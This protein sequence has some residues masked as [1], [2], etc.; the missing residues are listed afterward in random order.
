MNPDELR[1][2]GAETLEWVARYQENVEQLP[3]ALP[4]GARRAAQAAT[5]RAPEEP[6]PFE[7]I[8]ADLDDLIL[9]GITHWQ[10]PNF[11]AYFPA[12]TSGPSILGELVTAGLAVNG[13]LWSTSPACTEL[14]MHVLDWLL[15]LCGLPDRFRSSGPGGGVIQDSAS[16]ATLCALVAA[17]DR[18]G[19]R[20]NA[21]QRSPG[22]HLRGRPFV[23]AEGGS[24]R[25]P[26]RR[27]ASPHRCRRRARAMRPDALDD[28]MADDR[29]A[30]YL[31]FFVVATAGTTSSLA[32]DPVDAIA[33]RC[34][35]AWLH[36][37]GAM[38]GSAAVCPELRWVVDGLERADSYCFNP[39]KWLFTNFDC[40]CFYIAD[41]SALT[42][43]LSVTP[44]YLRNPASDSGEVVDYR[45]WQVPLGRRFRALKL[46]FVLRWFG[47]EG[48]RTQI[49][50]HVALTQELAGWIE[51]DERFEVVAPVRLN[52][53]CFLHRD[54]DEATQ[55]VL[56]EA[57]RSGALFLTHTKL[58]G[59]TVLRMCVGQTNTERRHVHAAWERLAEH[60]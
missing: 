42:D 10:S 24:D 46:W 12:N 20:G 16:S 25:R 15:D 44:E 17:R 51:E 19:R 2:W 53:V 14:E 48:L 41:R 39:H 33:D 54:G 26:R 49:R 3:G 45:D 40:D 35:G 34:G 6:E 28:A 7:R 30:G 36:V 27:P 9:P 60:G 52:L 59:R 38:A 31:P 50:E 29:A 22:L 57:N 37:D 8:L 58:D 1:R 56:H 55:R 11:F 23:G 32:F 18:A 21:P 5:R 13:M 4:G 43:A 47:A